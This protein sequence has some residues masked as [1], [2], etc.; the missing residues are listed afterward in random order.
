MASNPAVTTGTKPNFQA[1]PNFQDCN[2][3]VMITVTG[4]DQV[5]FLGY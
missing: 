3:I 1:K 4:L 2:K 5:I